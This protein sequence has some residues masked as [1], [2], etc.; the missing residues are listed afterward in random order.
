[1]LGPSPCPAWAALVGLGSRL[2]QSSGP[3]LGGLQGVGV[4]T[5]T[6]GHIGGSPSACGGLSLALG[7]DQGG[8]DRVGEQG[9]YRGGLPGAGEGGRGAPGGTGWEEGHHGK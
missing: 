4:H 8:R 9:R 7:G 3:G 5:R 6:R 2:R 1:M